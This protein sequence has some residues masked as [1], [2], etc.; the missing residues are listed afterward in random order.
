LELEFLCL[1]L[2][3]S[4]ELLRKFIPSPNPELIEISI[5]GN[6]ATFTLSGELTSQ[7]EWL[8][9][10]VRSKSDNL[11]L[12]KIDLADEEPKFDVMVRS[13]TVSEILTNN[14]ANA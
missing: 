11:I 14:Y 10:Q 4:C 1:W 5:D 7:I 6:I 8:S 13:D 12:L 3:S 9:E 2:K